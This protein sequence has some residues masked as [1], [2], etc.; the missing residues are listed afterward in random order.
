MKT[1]LVL[2]LAITRVLARTGHGLV[3]YG[4]GEDS[5]LPYCAFSCRG[6]ISGATLNCSM[7]MDMDGMQMTTTDSSCYATDDAF[8]QTLAYCVSQKCA[9]IPVW[10]LERWWKL[11]VAG[12]DD[13][14]PDPKETY[15]E[16]LLKAGTPAVVYAATGSL[17]Q[18]SIVSDAL[19]VP[20]YTTNNVFWAGEYVQTRYGLVIL[21]SGVIFPIAF[22]LLRFLPFP[23]VW[24]TKF[25]AVVIEAPL[26]G[27]KHDTYVFNGLFQMPKRGQ[28][29]LILYFIIL[30]FVVLNAVNYNY[31]G[32]SNTWYPNDRTRWIEMQISNRL[33]LISFVNMPLLFVYAGRNNV[34]RWVTDWS[35]STFLFLHSWIAAIATIEAILHSLIYL[36]AYVVSGT[37][38]S[39]SKLPYWYWGAAATIAMAVLLP[40]SIAPLRR[41][42]YEPFLA[43]HVALS[44]LALAGCYWHIVFRY[45]HQ[46]GYEALIIVCTA[47]W[48]FDRVARVLRFARHGVQT[49]HIAVIDDTYVRITVPGVA[50]HG[51]AYLYFPTLSWRVWENHPFSVAAT[52]LAPTPRPGTD[53]GTDKHTDGRDVES[54]R[55]STLKKPR[56]AASAPLPGTTIYARTEHGLTACLRGRTTLPVL[57]EGDYPSHPP[58]AAD[59]RRA[60]TLVALAAGVGV[61]A[62]LPHVRAHPGRAVLHWGA[63]T[64]ALVDDV[65]R[66]VPFGAGVEAEVVVGR[67]LDVR[68]ILER[69]LVGATGEVCVL[70]CGP[71]GML[72]EVRAAFGEI[73]GREKVN[74]RLEVESFSW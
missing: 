46:W 74:A 24:R 4:I 27:N 67:R 17:N 65:R 5:F 31:P 50:T 25:N 73:V 47:I 40:T 42:L 56:G 2:T 66:T 20:A 51:H 21:L 41:K 53:A 19:W 71:A 30:N 1:I 14:Q 49:A 69:E 60:P 48:A 38:A 10:R 63:R 64:A 22:S 52:T 35:H 44:I 62:V 28:A 18:T 54:D 45:A 70:A 9:D 23:A 34:L 58:L 7:T 32:D 72:D 26:F 29:L 57:V 59:P 36:R 39:E 68:A 33:G 16:A 6:A 8:L 43:W 12:I 3:G 13:V 37:H 61:T 15:G 55:G 11:N